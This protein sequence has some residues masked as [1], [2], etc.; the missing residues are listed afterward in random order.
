MCVF[1]AQRLKLF[2]VTSARW[3][4]VKEAASG[5]RRVLS[6][7]RG[8]AEVASAAYHLVM[9]LCFI[10]YSDVAPQLPMRLKKTSC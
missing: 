9:H 4:Q 10:M 3:H 8:P 6:S 7:V 1:K 2:P 5:V